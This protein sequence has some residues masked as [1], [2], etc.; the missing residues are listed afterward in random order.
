MAPK[1]RFRDVY[2]VSSPPRDY[3]G[4]DIAIGMR[5]V[6]GRINPMTNKPAEA[7]EWL[8]ADDSF[9]GGHTLYGEVVKQSGDEVE[10]KDIG[11]PEGLHFLFEPLTMSL[12]KKLLDGGFIRASD[13]LASEKN[14]GVLKNALIEDVLEEWWVESPENV[15]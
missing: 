7:I 3:R 1:F 15:W 10:V 13:G 14:I 2:V 11:S 8:A 5:V 9:K 4:I 6:S 12:W